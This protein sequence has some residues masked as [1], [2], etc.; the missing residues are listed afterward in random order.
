[1][2]KRERALE[3][4]LIQSRAEVIALVDMHPYNTDD[5]FDY[6]PTTTEVERAKANIRVEFPR[7][8]RKT[9]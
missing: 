7:T 5:A 3:K 4:A 9:K 8:K 1:M 2:T 6:T